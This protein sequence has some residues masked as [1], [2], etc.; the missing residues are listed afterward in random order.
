M[1]RVVKIVD[2]IT[3]V[4]ID[5]EDKVHAITITLTEA[6]TVKGKASTRETKSETFEVSAETIEMLSYLIAGNLPE[7]LANVPKSVKPAQGI[8]GADSATIRTWALA[9]VE[10]FTSSKGKLPAEVIKAYRQAQEAAKG[11]THSQVG[12]PPTDTVTETTTVEESAA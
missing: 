12:T 2:D 7:F 3:D 8:S 6:I 4:D 11:V 9:N 5:G 1:A 10:G